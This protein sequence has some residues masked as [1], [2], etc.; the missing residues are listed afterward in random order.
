[1]KFDFTDGDKIKK[2]LFTILTTESMWHEY[3][4]QEIEETLLNIEN[5]RSEMLNA[6]VD[7]TIMLEMMLEPYIDIDEIKNANTE[8]GILIIYQ[9]YINNKQLIEQATGKTW[10]EM[11]E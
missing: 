10:E 2:R 5:E 9:K 1:M 11:N 3:E 4:I 8:M 6:L 7:T